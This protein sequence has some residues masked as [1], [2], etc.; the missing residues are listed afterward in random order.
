VNKPPYGTL[1]AID[2]GRGELLWQITLGDSPEIRNHPLLEGAALPARLGVA[3]S[4][5][6]LVTRGGLIF[7]S[8][9]GNVLY[10]LDAT[11]GRELWSHDFGTQVYANPMTYRARDGRQYVVVATGI[12][13]NAALV[14]FALR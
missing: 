12:G 13:E 3:G 11:D 4:P 14:G 2:L 7:V 6:P 8:G 1:T 5:G 10:A 9:G